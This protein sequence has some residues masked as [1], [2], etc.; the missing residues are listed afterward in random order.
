M[1]RRR[2]SQAVHQSE[3]RVAHVA[4][5]H[6]QG[7]QQIDRGT[8]AQGGVDPEARALDRERV[9]AVIC[10]VRVEVGAT[11]LASADEAR[12]RARFDHAAERA[13]PESTDRRH[14]LGVIV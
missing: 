2:V 5:H 8:E 10:Y 12:G 1:I 4:V 13:D 11:H 6:R 14:V 3:R 7:G 9:Q